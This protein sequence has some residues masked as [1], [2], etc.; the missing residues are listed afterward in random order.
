MTKPILILQMQRMGDILLTFPLLSFL[1]HLFPHNPLWT[2]ADSL[3]F[4]DLVPFAP[5]T[6]FFPHHAAARLQNTSFHSVINVSHREDAAR[7]AGTVDAEHRFGAHYRG[8]HLFIGGAWAL[9]RTGLVEN[10]RHNL[11]HWSDLYVLDHIKQAQLPILHCNARHT[12]SASTLPKVGIFVGASEREKRPS[13]TFFGNLAK[14][15][16]RKN[17]RPFFLG[18]PNDVALGQEAVRIA[19]ISR[20]AHISLCGKLSLAQLASVMKELSLCI[21]PDTGPMHLATWLQTPVLNLSLGHVNAWETGPLLP[22]NY[23][24]RPTLSC[25]GCWNACN[26]TERCHNKI[27]P[28]RVAHLAHSIIHAPDKLT[29]LHLTGTQFFRTGRDAHGLY[30]LSPIGEKK[31]CE[32]IEHSARMLLS[33]FWQEWFWQIHRAAQPTPSAHMARLAHMYPPLFE[34]LN[35]SAIHLGHKLHQHLRR[36]HKGA[37]PALEQSFWRNIPPFL[38][39]LSGH[40][41]IFLQNENYSTQAWGK[42]LQQIENLHYVLAQI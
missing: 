2:V 16:V 26:H 35:A 18:G 28:E 23:V 30:T 22:N 36:V 37:F 15:L 1:Q 27:H 39:P 32:Q 12:H 19:G 14:N 33:R 4:P 7:L 13:A 42:V 5:K 25:A 24:L 31:Y 3:F 11:F 40:I 34:A 6:V 10:N 29:R 17:L 20:S 38:R 8:K 9:H 21:T 41:H